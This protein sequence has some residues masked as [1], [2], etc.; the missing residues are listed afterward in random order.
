VN[1]TVA[2]R[3]RGEVT[4]RLGYVGEGTRVRV[5]RYRARIARGRWRIRGLLPTQAARSGGQLSIQYTGD[6]RR[7]IR[8]EH[9][10]RRL[11]P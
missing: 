2:R 5:L 6:M 1:G 4:V 9:L 8:G 7:R 3:A 11:A 10:I